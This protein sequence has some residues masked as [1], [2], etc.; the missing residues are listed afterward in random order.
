M[1]MST[2][3]ARRAALGMAALGLLVAGSGCS[4]VHWRPDL[5]GAMRM[6]AERN[7]VVVAAYW[8]TFNK[9]CRQMENEVFTH[10]D[11]IATL[12]ST[13][14][15]KLEAWSNKAFAET[16]NLRTVPSFVV[17]AP[18]GRV[19]RISEGYLNEGRFRGLIEA[20]RLSN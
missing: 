16:H 18:D 11:V 4:Q 6:A 1:V 5:G 8:S 13:I 12:K 9:D 20:A 15:V 14:P 10:P 3:T 2:Q 17:L 19:L 7:T